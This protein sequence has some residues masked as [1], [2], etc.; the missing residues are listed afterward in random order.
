MRA[1]EKPTI[2]Y[3]HQV[4]KELDKR[5]ASYKNGKAEIVSATESKK[6]VLQIL[7]SATTK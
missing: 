5:Y 4:K 6:R 7:K 1:T 2:E 3:T